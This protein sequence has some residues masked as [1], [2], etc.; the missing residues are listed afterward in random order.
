MDLYRA[1]PEVA[2][3]TR[4]SAGAHGAPSSAPRPY[5]LFQPAEV[6]EARRGRQPPPTRF[7]D[8]KEALQVAQGFWE[9]QPTAIPHE[10][11]EPTGPPCAR[12]YG[13]HPSRACTAF[14][15]PCASA[16]TDWLEV[17]SLDTFMVRV[18]RALKVGVG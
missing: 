18:G 11:A 14:S 1:E 13:P 16:V 3:R 4:R 2:H 12:C 5:R 17:D 6:E 9:Q 15:Q 10:A 8:G 7:L